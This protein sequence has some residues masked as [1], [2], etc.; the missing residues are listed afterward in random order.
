MKAI[1]KNK[2]I[3][4]FYCFIKIIWKIFNLFNNES[5]IL[6]GKGTGTN[7]DSP[8][9]KPILGGWDNEKYG[10]YIIF[11]NFRNKR[12]SKNISEDIWVIIEDNS[13]FFDIYKIALTM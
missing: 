13:F 3:Y 8:E 6:T 10:K 2:F 11:F 12:H 4:L 9:M 7:G 1:L 5:V